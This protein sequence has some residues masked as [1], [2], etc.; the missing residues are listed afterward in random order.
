MLTIPKTAD[1]PGNMPLETQ[2]REKS[3]RGISQVDR[4]L[5]EAEHGEDIQ[6]GIADSADSEKPKN[7]ANS[8]DANIGAPK[9]DTGR[10]GFKHD[11]DEEEVLAGVELDVDISKKKKRPRRSKGKRGAVSLSLNP[12]LGRGSTNNSSIECTHGVRTFLCRC[13]DDSCGIQGQ[14]ENL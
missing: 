14:S 3:S 7:T 2:V 8:S 10:I 1:F 13:P 12:V 6:D 11:P 5:A 9:T 4:A